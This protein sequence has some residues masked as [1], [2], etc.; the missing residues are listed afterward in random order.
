[1]KER[2]L[3]ISTVIFIGLLI[4]QCNYHN[5][6]EYFDVP[7]NE[8][9]DTLDISFSGYIFPLI[10]DNCASCHNDI[11]TYG[12]R[13]YDTYEGIKEVAETGLILNVLNHEPGFV[14]MPKDANKL[15]DCDLS[16]IEAWINQGIKNN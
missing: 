8:L 11:T 12:E 7:S 15:P 10:V 4:S 13:N 2:I 16:K 6:E 9:C 5:V 1:M 14:Q 3:Y